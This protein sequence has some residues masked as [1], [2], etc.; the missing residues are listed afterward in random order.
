MFEPVGTKLLGRDTCWADTLRGFL[1]R[2][3]LEFGFWIRFWGLD[4]GVLILDS[5]SWILDFG[6]WILLLLLLLLSP[7]SSSSSSLKMNLN[8][9]VKVSLGK[10]CP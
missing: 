2:R 7:P 4:F 6:F 1:I 5:G 9:A 8:D 10:N 3:Y